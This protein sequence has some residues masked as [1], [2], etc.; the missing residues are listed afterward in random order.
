MN[1]RLPRAP[2]YIRMPADAFGRSTTLHVEAAAMAG[3][4]LVAVLLLLGCNA[5]LVVR[6]RS[7]AQVIVH[8]KYQIAARYRVH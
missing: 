5:Q 3:Q 7:R 8:E 2:T 4:R 6:I 1:E